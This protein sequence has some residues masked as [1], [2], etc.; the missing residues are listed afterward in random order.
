MIRAVLMALALALALFAAQP[1]FAQNPFA[2]PPA[3]QPSEAQAAPVPSPSW[4]QSAVAAVQAWQSSLYRQIATSLRA[5]KDHGAIGPLFALLGIAF[6]YGVLH[7]AGPGHGK[8]VIAAYLAADDSAFA[9]GIVLSFL[10]SAAQAFT[11]IAGVGIL[12]V[13]A[14]MFARDV[15]AFAFTLERISYLMI[16][17]VGIYL[18]WRGARGW[19]GF[20]AKPLVHGP[21]QHDHAGH[22]HHRN[23]GHEHDHRHGPNCAHGDHADHLAM[24]TEKPLL[25]NLRETAAVIASVGIRPCQGSV[26]IL[27][28]ATAFGIFWAGVLAA[29]AVALG[30]ALTVSAIAVLT[31]AARKTANRMLGARPVWLDRSARA[32]AVAAGLFIAWI[33]IALAVAPPPPLAPGL[34]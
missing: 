32:L 6:M 22:D 9:R 3:N 27:L 7:A 16:A 18:I 4:T 28:L 20:G 1:S 12:A 31:V 33:G 25:G 8:A 15:T 10:S 30:T 21:D 11:A 17:G 24:P 19:L 14:G 26:F 13:V 34:G 29:L 5:L 2:A 23:H